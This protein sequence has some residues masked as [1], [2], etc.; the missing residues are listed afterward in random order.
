VSPELI[1]GPEPGP[2]TLARYD[3]AWPARFERERA[4]ILAALG[5]AVLGIEHVGSTSV[6]T[7]AAKPIV[8]IDVAVAA[9]RTRRPSSRRWST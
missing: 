8:D 1:G 7:L 2:V 4:R 5:D 6:P 3:P 9:R